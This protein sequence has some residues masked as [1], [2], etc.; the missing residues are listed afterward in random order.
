MHSDDSWLRARER[1]DMCLRRPAHG[2]MDLDGVGTIVGTSTFCSLFTHMVGL[3]VC[4]KR[5]TVFSTYITELHNS[6]K[7]EEEK[8]VHI[9]INQMKR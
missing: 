1:E 6:D 9:N 2:W 3:W 5:E 8:Y 4:G 7:I